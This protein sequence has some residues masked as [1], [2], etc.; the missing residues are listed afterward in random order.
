MISKEV[1]TAAGEL[2]ILFGIRDSDYP[3]WKLQQEI[4]TILVN[5]GVKKKTK[6]KWY[7]K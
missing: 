6:L 1:A 2:S 7:Q 4:H 5:S 3:Q